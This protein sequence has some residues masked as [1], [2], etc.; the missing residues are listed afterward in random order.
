MWYFP[1]VFYSALSVTPANEEFAKGFLGG[2][3]MMDAYE[4]LWIKES[5]LVRVRKEV[6]SL[7][8]VATYSRRQMRV[9]L[10]RGLTMVA[11]R[12]SSSTVRTA[13]KTLG[14]TGLSPTLLHSCPSQK[15]P[16]VEKA[17]RSQA[18]RKLAWS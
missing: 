17:H 4:L 7:R 13:T 9:M 18:V 10:C 15:K 6:E 14:M 12:P 8:I 3:S 5:D 1:P 2:A 11:A 16:T